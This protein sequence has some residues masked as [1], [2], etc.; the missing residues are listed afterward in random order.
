[1]LSKRR[2][3]RCPTQGDPP[4]KL[5]R[6]GAS[7]G[8]WKLWIY[9]HGGATGTTGSGA[10]SDGDGENASRPQTN[11]NLAWCI[12]TMRNI[13]KPWNTISSAQSR[14]GDGGRRPGR[15][16]VVEMEVVGVQTILERGLPVPSGVGA[17]GVVAEGGLRGG[18]L[19]YR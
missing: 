16:A 8:Q 7:E 15:E 10:T 14:T 9:G 1:M 12:K 3:A 18:R 13:L 11:K 6:S 2:A 17:C 4:E 19:T 5:S